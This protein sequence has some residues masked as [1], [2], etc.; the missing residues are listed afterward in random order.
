M[1]MATRVQTL[2]ETDCISI[3]A[4]CISIMAKVLD[5]AIKFPLRTNAPVKETNP[6]LMSFYKGG[7]GARGVMD[8]D[9]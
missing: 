8:L 1:D 6:Q 9:F 2:D 5:C 7:F 3:M 4:D